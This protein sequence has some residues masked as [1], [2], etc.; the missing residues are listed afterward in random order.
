MFWRQDQDEDFAF[1]TDLLSK[2]DLGKFWG[3][4]GW[5]KIKKMPTSKL[6]ELKELEL[7]P[8]DLNLLTKSVS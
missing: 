2:V 6:S 4:S 1:R 8:S 3:S 5:T 7:L